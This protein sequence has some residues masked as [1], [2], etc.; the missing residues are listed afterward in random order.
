[1]GEQYQLKCTLQCHF[2]VLSFSY[3]VF[4]GVKLP[5]VDTLLDLDTP[6]LTGS[7]I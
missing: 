7:Q 2:G 3:P 1:M 5:N 6:V 4:C